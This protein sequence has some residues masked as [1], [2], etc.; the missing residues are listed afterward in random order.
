MIESRP[1]EGHYGQLLSNVETET[2]IKNSMYKHL[3]GIHDPMIYEFARF[4]FKGII[5][6]GRLACKR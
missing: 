2:Q 4:K 5:A 6:Y 3:R 1:V